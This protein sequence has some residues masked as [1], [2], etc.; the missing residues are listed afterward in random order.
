MPVLRKTKFVRDVEVELQRRGF[1]QAFSLPG[2]Y[3]WRRA[4]MWNHPGF[5][6]R[7]EIRASHQLRLR[8]PSGKWRI[9]SAKDF[10]EAIEILDEGEGTARFGDD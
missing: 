4:S 9:L 5:G 6:L 10:A 7:V 8:F 2:V 1:V 3:E